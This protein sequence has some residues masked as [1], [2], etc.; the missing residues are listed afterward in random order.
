MGVWLVV[1]GNLL[2]DQQ[3]LLALRRHALP[4]EVVS[5]KL[6]EAVKVIDVLTLTVNN[7]IVDSKG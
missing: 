4:L 6:D 7:F 1:V 5:G 3:A 2:A